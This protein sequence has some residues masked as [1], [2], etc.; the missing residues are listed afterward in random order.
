MNQFKFDIEIQ[1]DGRLEFVYSDDRVPY[2]GEILN[3]I[4]AI[5][6]RVEATT[7]RSFVVKSVETQ[8]V[9]AMDARRDEIV[10]RASNITVCVEE[11]TE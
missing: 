3:C 8:I 4:G 1:L 10:N 9:S 5:P 11:I 6:F 2:V 7:N